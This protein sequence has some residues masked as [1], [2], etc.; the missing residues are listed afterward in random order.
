[1]Y[2]VTLMDDYGASGI[3]L[4]FIVI[5]E[6]ISIAWAYGVDKFFDNVKEM[7]GYYP[8]AFVKYCWFLF[9]PL[10]CIVSTVLT[11]KPTQTT[12]QCSM[13]KLLLG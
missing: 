12:C 8:I 3:C 4:L 9:C 5:A 1:M 10:I 11:I 13:S 7:I 2:V 6:C